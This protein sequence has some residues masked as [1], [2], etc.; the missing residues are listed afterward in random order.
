VLRICSGSPI[1]RADHDADQ[2]AEA[3]VDERLAGAHH[4]LQLL[5]AGVDR[6][7]RHVR[8]AAGPRDV[9]AGAHPR[10]AV[11]GVLL[12]V[13]LAVAVAR[14][15]EIGQAARTGGG[16]LR[17]PLVDRVLDVAVGLGGLLGALGDA[18]QEALGLVG[19]VLA[20][21]QALEVLERHQ[22]AERAEAVVAHPCLFEQ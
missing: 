18:L 13:A 19:H 5:H 17:Q 3:V 7:D 21:L 8:R 6:R 1:D 20:F 22:L 4:E 15:V 11:A 14:A 10:A 16:D 2:E 9:A 12:E